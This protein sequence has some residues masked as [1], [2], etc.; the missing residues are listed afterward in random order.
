MCAAAIASGFPVFVGFFVDSAFEQLSPG[1]VAPAPN[2]NDPNGGGHAVYL[3]AFKR[4]NGKRLFTLTN[5]WGNW[6]DNGQCL[7]GDEWLAKVW[8]L[9]VMD[10]GV[11]QGAA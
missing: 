10:V 4:V 2:E 1:Q 11:V 3:S 9:L 7:V 8:D 6:C 5:S